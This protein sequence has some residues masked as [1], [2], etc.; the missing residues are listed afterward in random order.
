MEVAEAFLPTRFGKFRIYVFADS[1]K[2]HVTLVACNHKIHEGMP[3]RVHSKCFTGDT[4]VSLRCDCRAQLEESLRYMKKKR[5]GILIYLD[6][7]GRGIGLFNKIKAYAL[8]DQ[9]LDTV[10]ANTH[11]GF[12]DDLREYSI[13]AKILQYFGANDIALLTNNPKKIEGLRKYGILVSKIIPIITR[14]NKYNRKYIETKAKKM[15][16]LIKIQEVDRI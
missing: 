4:F 6:Q 14:T 7:E 5:C 10:E 16:H 11:L 15:N 1:G 2:E 13:A 8:Q 12:H 3:V 9:G